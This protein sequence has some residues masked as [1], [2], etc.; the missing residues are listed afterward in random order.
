MPVR[1][2]L[3]GIPRQ[4]AGVDGLD[5]EAENLGTAL[6]MLAAAVPDFARSCLEQGRLK[7]GYIANLNGHSF[8]SDPRTPLAD[9]DSLLILSADAG[10]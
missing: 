3:Y 8:T 10:G 7:T 5:V 2:E 1:I 4:R 9:G 6:E